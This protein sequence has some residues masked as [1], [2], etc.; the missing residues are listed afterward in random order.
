VRFL[1]LPPAMFSAPTLA[2]PALD[3]DADL[4]VFAYGSL[5]W[6]PG[7]ALTESQPALLRGWRRSF[8]IYSRQHRGTLE[9]P[10]VV[11]GLDRGG[12]CRGLA[13]RA[14]HGQAQAVLD[15]LWRREMTY[16]VYRPRWV[17]LLSPRGP[18]TALA[19]TADRS[20]PQYCGHLPLAAKATLIR[21][22]VGESGSNVDYLANLIASLAALG[23]VDGS[24]QALA[25][26]LEGSFNPAADQP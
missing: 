19:F 12:A 2:A 18:L 11:L 10:G 6:N 23:V 25:R 5:M 4:W 9:R 24:L 17:R 22:G 15:Y 3:G 13:L 8:C 21:Q 14:A 20:H 26:T 1:D 16:R 7:F